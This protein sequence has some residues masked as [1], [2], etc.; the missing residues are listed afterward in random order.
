ML[1]LHATTCIFHRTMKVLFLMILM[2]ALLC[3]SVA[4]SRDSENMQDPETE[5]NSL[6][7]FTHLLFLLC[8]NVCCES[9]QY[10]LMTGCC[11]YSEICVYFGRCATLHKYTALINSN[12]CFFLLCLYLLL[13]KMM[14][15]VQNCFYIYWYYH[16]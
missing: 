14:F 3:L 4:V 10:L 1:Q 7:L 9:V 8:Q 13:F 6:L 16:L 2:M 12:E 11:R 15:P 5:A